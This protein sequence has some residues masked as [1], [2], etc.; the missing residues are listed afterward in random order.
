M[1]ELPEHTIEK[2]KMKWL[3]ILERSFGK[4]VEIACLDGAPIGFMQYAP[5]ELFVRVRNYASGPPGMDAVFIA[6]LYII[7]KEQR[8]KGYGT[9]MLEK[10]L[11][12][13]RERNYKAVETFARSDSENNP[14]GPLLFYLKH[15]FEV[16]RQKDNFPLV[17]LEI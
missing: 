10:I 6:C 1:H 17:H 16:I 7:N 15:G 3:Y 14:S 13:V 12:E 9:V 2:R 8:K 5:A 4:G 11:R